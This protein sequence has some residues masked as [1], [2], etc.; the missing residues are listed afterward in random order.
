ME[1][2]IKEDGKW[3]SEIG[4]ENWKLDKRIEVGR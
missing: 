4:R 1:D 2:S 3:K